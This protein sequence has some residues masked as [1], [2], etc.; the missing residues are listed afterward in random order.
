MVGWHNE[1]W[2]Y[3]KISAT[4]LLEVPVDLQRCIRVAG[5]IG[6]VSMKVHSISNNFTL[7]NVK[8]FALVANDAII[9]VFVSPVIFLLGLIII[10]FFNV[11]LRPVRRLL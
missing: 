8:F 7:S 3:V 2:V 5:W 9:H 6:V 10:P 1:E 4:T 11:K